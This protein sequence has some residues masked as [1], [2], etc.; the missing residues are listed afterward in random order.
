MGWSVR[1]RDRMTCSCSYHGPNR[2]SS[3]SH[4]GRGEEPLLARWVL[5]NSV[6]R[7][8]GDGQCIV[9][10]T[11][12]L[13][14]HLDRPRI[15]P[16]MTSQQGYASFCPLSHG[17][18]IRLTHLVHEHHWHTERE[19]GESHH[20]KWK[21]HL[22]LRRSQVSH[23]RG[24]LGSTCGDGADDRHPEGPEDRHDPPLAVETLCHS[25]GGQKGEVVL[26]IG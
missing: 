8:E 6:L 4:G 17:S 11:A 23:G 26:F 14:P 13:E 16:R 7:W 1:E 20:R 9:N 5:R 22:G 2:S 10:A 12:G 25:S 15:R 21:E 3:E 24:E 18:S 19:R